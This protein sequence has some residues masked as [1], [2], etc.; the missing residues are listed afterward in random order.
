MLGWEIIGPRREERVL[1]GKVAGALWLLVPPM[2]GVG[3]FLP[4]TTTAH[5]EV[6]AL[7]ALPAAAWGA[8]CLASIQ[9]ERVESPLVYHVPASLAG[10]YIAVV[11]AST[12][13]TESPFAFAFLMLIVFC[14]YFFTPPAAMA[15][16]AGSLVLHTLPLTYD[17]G[18]RGNGLLPQLWVAA[19]VYCS[20]GGVVMVGKGQLLALRDAA[21]ELSRR[22]SLTGLGNRRALTDTLDAR[23][24]GM[25]STD[26][27]GLI[28]LDL[29]EFKEANTLHGLTGGDEVLRAVGN[30]LRSVSRR[31]DLVVRLGGDEFAILVSNASSPGMERLAGRVVEK[32]RET[33]LELDLPG[34]RLT[35]SAGW[36]LYP[37]HV[38]ELEELVAAADLSLRAAKL[39][40]KN[41]SHAPVDWSRKAS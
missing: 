12:G 24:G 14:A 7:A 30:A 37:N 6:V 20:V 9:W 2:F 33:A 4:G 27:F 13:G 29:D 32:V 34:Y 21:Q 10:P 23:R 22:D 25:R 39:S 26:S 40:G 19:C 11:I 38:S 8:I 16:I 5:W 17:A 31:G 35:A 36:A 1:A 28:L 15:Y 18:W 41:R 3:V